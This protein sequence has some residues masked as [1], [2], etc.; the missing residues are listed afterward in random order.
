M[1]DYEYPG[2]DGKYHTT[3]FEAATPAT[4]TNNSCVSNFPVAS[5]QTLHRQRL[6]LLPQC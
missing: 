3:Y 6:E 4:C 5:K 1:A 2:T